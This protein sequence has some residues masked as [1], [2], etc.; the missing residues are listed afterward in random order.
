[1]SVLAFSVDRKWTIA[2]C[3]V[4]KL[5][6]SN[7]SVYPFSVSISTVSVLQ[8]LLEAVAV[9]LIQPLRTVAD[10]GWLEREFQHVGH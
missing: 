10:I 2:P 3:A 5:T 9:W 7:L 1:M 8:V 4:S 6:I